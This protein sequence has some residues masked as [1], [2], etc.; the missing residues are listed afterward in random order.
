MTTSAQCNALLN[1]TCVNLGG[2]LGSVCVDASN[3][4]TPY[5]PADNEIE[6]VGTQNS[7]T[8]DDC[9]GGG[10][11][12]II[13]V[14]SRTASISPQAIFDVRG[15]GGG[16]C[17]ICAG[18][19]GGG[20]G[21]LQIDS[22]YSGEICDGWDNDFNGTPDDGL[23]T[24]P[25]QGGPDI[26]AC[27][28]GVPQVCAPDPQTCL[29]PAHDARPR[30][31][32]VVD[33]SGSMLYDLAGYPTFGD[34]SVDFPGVDTA[35]DPDSTPGNN[36]RLF[37]AKQALTQVLSAFPESDYALARYYQDVGVNRS[38]QTAA[39]FE[40]AMSCCSY[41]D[42]SNNIAPPYPVTY[43]NNECLLAQLYPAAG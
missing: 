8:C 31:A 20:A 36:S 32:L 39:N 40:C 12:G 17:P 27:Q 21:E 22:G 35:S 15:A 23:G 11:G 34:G 9:G 6:C 43:P 2:A 38:C 37:I 42:P 18:E 13:N 14:Q 4:C 10:G 41:D 5:D 16:I 28:G 29:V 7:G 3:Q 30:F 25:C 1:Q 24:I 26:P 33:T 19:A